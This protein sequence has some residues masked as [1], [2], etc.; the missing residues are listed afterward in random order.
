MGE[1]VRYSFLSRQHGLQTTTNTLPRITVG[2]K[3]LGCNDYKPVVTR[4]S[5]CHV[6][7]WAAAIINSF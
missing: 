5:M 7:E 3:C 2:R 4:A 1:R 6:D